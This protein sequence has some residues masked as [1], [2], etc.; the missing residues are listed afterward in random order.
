[1]TDHRIG[2]TLHSLPG[3][4]DGDLEEFHVALIADDVARI[5]AEEA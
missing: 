4:L 3:V 2:M 5:L 1:M